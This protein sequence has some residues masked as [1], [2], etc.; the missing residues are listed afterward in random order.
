MKKFIELLENEMEGMA[1]AP[2]APA[3]EPP[4][5]APAPEEP[6]DTQ[7]MEIADV[8]LAKELALRVPGISSADRV[9]L[10]VQVSTGNV[11]QVREKLQEILNIYD[12]P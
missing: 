1:P 3:D 2:E 11:Q 4:P 12:T 7:S 6:V 10:S 5:P 9:A 8:T